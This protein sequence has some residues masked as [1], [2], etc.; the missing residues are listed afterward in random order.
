[1]ATGTIVLRP[2][3]DVSIEHSKSNRYADAC[4]LIADVSADDDS[5]YIYST[6]TAGGML[7]SQTVT[8]ESVFL[9]TPQSSLPNDKYNIVSVRLYS[10][11]TLGNNGESGEYYCYFVVGTDEGGISNGARVGRNLGSSYQTDSIESSALVDDFNSYIAESFP[12]V[13]VRVFS[14]GRADSGNKAS[15]GYI[16]I[17]QVY[18]EIDY[19]TV[20]EA[21]PVLYI[22]ENDN[23]NPCLGLYR[24]ENGRWVDRTSEM[25]TIIVEIDN[26]I[27]KEV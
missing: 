21:H 7:G 18:M 10:R 13:S 27:K 1:M 11:A 22:K 24:K 19:E 26:Y 6:L 4:D 16:R 12:V 2:S 9:L 25:K 17:T 3:S 8:D 15:D 20:E 5:T 23:W 14:Q